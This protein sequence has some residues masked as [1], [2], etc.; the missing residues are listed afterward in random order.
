ME[1]LKLKT[2]VPE[3]I[4]LAFADGKPVQSQFGGDQVF[5]SLVDG[6]GFYCA[7]FVAQKIKDAGIGARQV[8]EICKRET[9]QGNRRIVEYQIDREASYQPEA[10]KPIET[11]AS[12]EAAST[13]Y[14]QSSQVQAVPTVPTTPTQSSYN[15][16]AVRA[17]PPLSEW[18][19]ERRPAPIA[20]SSVS[21]M[22]VAGCGAIDVVL[23]VENY[24]RAKGMTDFAFDPASIQDLVVSLFISME[25]KA[26]RA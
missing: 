18:F 5:F 14:P 21:L 20:E 22:K 15:G 9:T 26:G 25:K 3:L 11:A 8:F 16:N 12:G 1:T 6:R 24:A 4:A 10:R 23:E 17:L 19:P 2:N 13:S 7:P